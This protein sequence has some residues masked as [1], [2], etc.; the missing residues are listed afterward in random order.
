MISSQLAR[1]RSNR[2]LSLALTG[3]AIFM[4]S[5]AR[6]SDSIQDVLGAS[7]S[8]R[9][10]YWNKDKSFSSTQDFVVGSM[11]LTLRPADAFGYRFFFDGYIQANNLARETYSQGDAREAFVEKSLG[12]FDFKL[13]R[14]IVVWGRADKL[15]PTDSFSSRDF[16][17]LT[18]DDED[19]RRGQFAVQTVFNLDQLRLIGIWQPE[20]RSP[21]YP[22]APQTGIEIQSLNPENP[23]S[24]FG[25]KVDSSGGETDW[26][27][28]YFDGYN[29]V[30]DLRV[31]ATGTVNQLGL[32][33]GHIRVYGADF[34]KAI[35]EFGVRG[36]IAYSQT[37][38]NQGDNPLKQNSNLFAV[39]GA[40][41]TIAENLN[42]N[43]QI[44]YRN[45]FGH[46]D[47]NLISD[48]NTRAI[49]TQVAITSNQLYQEQLGLSLRPSYKAFHET[50]E[51]EVAFVTWFKN[52]DSIL[53]PKV[54]YAVND[55]VKF[56][57]GA[58]FYRGP[59]NTFFGRLKD[60]SSVFT[61]LRVLF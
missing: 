1:L 10:S 7:G 45:V 39:L 59:S 41:R 31:L 12:A 46:H 56:I 38:D 32:E 34:A 28:S 50:L 53:K 42:I 11:W 15:N 55:D 26:S 30:P 6:A 2:I 21:K 57:A 13:G 49:A 48:Q 3:F 22:I 5:T 23:Q 4:A 60:V 20:W 54:T 19:Q 17:L 18:T 33:Y 36:E 8:I 44:L 24:Q 16:G 35:G 58:E 61:E 29:R 47:P 43:S 9:G 14:Q 52:A 37:E 40:D 27:A 51:I 25:L